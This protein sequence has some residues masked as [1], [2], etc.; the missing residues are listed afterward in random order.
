MKFSQSVN[1]FGD[2]DIAK[3]RAA[4]RRMLICWFAALAVVLGVVLTLMFVNLYRV[5]VYHDRSLRGAG[6][7]VSVI[8]AIVFTGGSTF[9][10]SIKFRLTRKYV[11]MLR[12]MERGLKDETEV[13]FKS[14]D[15]A[16][17]FKDGVYFYT[18]VTDAKP[19]KREDITERR[20]L[21]EHTVKKPEFTEGQRIKITTH[22]NILISY[23]LEQTEETN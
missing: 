22:A 23:K 15:D 6:T 1:L 10:F 7:A 2:N 14:F 8:L 5:R 12:D 20:V 9:F 17:V 19:L 11:R 21:I 16:I 3:A 13:K 18:M 4:K